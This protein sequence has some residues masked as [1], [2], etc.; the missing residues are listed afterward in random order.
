MA[1][2]I[3]VQRVKLGFLWGGEFEWGSLFQSAQTDAREL[4][5]IACDPTQA[6]VNKTEAI[7]CQRGASVHNLFSPTHHSPNTRL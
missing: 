2:F 6:D 7:R 5:R 3:R 1:N 4:A